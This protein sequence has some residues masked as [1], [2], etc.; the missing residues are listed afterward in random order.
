MDEF[1]H[2]AGTTFEPESEAIGRR[3]SVQPEKADTLSGPIDKIASRSIALLTAPGAA[4]LIPSPV[5]QS[6]Q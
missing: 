5:S 1:G 2:A 4:A 6:Q 3:S